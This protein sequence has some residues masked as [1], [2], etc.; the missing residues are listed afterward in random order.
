MAQ[1]S[2]QVPTGGSESAVTF[3][4]QCNTAWL[5]LASKNSG[6]S[7]PTNGPGSAPAQFSDWMNTANASLVDWTLF[8]GANFDRIGTLDTL[9]SNWLP[10]LGGG[11][12]TA[13]S[14]SSVDLGAL[15][16]TQ[17]QITGSATINSFGSSAGVGEMKL[18]NA[19]GTWTLHNSAAMICPGG[20]DVLA[21]SGDTF[22]VA[23]QGS[24]VWLVVPF[25]RAGAAAGLGMPTGTLFW[26]YGSSAIS[27]AVIA[28][29]QTLGNTG[30]G[31]TYTGAAY[32]NLYSKVW[33]ESATGPDPEIVIS[34]AGRGGSALADWT[35]LKT[36]SLPDFRGRTPFGRDTMGF[37][38]AHR[39]DNT[40]VAPSRDTVG[41]I[42]GGNTRTILQANIPV[43]NLSLASLTWSGTW[44]QSANNLTWGQTANNITASWTNT[45]NGLVFSQSTGTITTTSNVTGIT[46]TTNAQLAS[47]GGT[48]T[49]TGSA[50]LITGSVTINDGGHFH[51]GSASVTGTVNG[52]VFGSNTIGGS[53]SGSVGGTISGTVSGSIGGTL[54]SGGSGTPL[55]TLNN[56]K[57][58]TWYMAL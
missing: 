7:Q 44:V 8:D 25:A 51:T 20:V 14:A 38:D 49:G 10:K 35:A 33:T 56:A 24:G 40:G 58:G 2:Y 15:R 48:V 42:G 43:Y 54:P 4:G 34:G 52:N 6:A 22:F 55:V 37:A 31:A 13:A 39:L 23:H 3:A 53:I 21:Q 12:G 50:N 41:S 1:G 57:L 9:N 19:S 45:S 16:Q 46:A 5:A 29:G 36:I 30:S 18:L 32:F 17:I 27:G 26:V 11:I 28:N 47:G